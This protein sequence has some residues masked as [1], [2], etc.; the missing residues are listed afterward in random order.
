MN[1]RNVSTVTILKLIK[2]VIH[3]TWS[4][5]NLSDD[6]PTNSK[7]L[8]I[9]LVLLETSLKNKRLYDETVNIKHNHLK[10]IYYSPI[11]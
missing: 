6:F 8:Y 3:K 2:V 11:S 7:F 5:G 10:I 1:D 4:Q 9:P